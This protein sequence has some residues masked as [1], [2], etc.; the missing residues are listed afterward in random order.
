MGVSTV[1]A[2]KE[3]K[4]KANELE[5]RIVFVKTEITVDYCVLFTKHSSPKLR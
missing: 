4:E 3:E 1:G 5:L 2:K